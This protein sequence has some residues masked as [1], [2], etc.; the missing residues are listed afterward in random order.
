MM[1]VKLINDE[2]NKIVL[3]RANCCISQFDDKCFCLCFCPGAEYGGDSE[4]FYSQFELHT[5]EQKMNQIILL[6]V[7]LLKMLLNSILKCSQS[8]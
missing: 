8:S 3:N 7:R 2:R 6:K 1:R 5:R 4:L